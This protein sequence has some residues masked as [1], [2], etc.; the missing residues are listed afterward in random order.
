M[1]SLFLFP[2]DTSEAALNFARQAALNLKDELCKLGVS[3]KEIVGD[4]ANELKIVNSLVENKDGSFLAFGHGAPELFTVH[5]DQHPVFFLRNTQHLSNFVCYFLSCCTGKKIGPAAINNGALAFFGFKEDFEFVP[6]YEENF[7]QCVTSGIRQ[8]LTGGCKLEE[9]EKIT[10]NSFNA[11]ISR[12][13]SNKEYYAAEK[14]LL[15]LSVMVF[16]IK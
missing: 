14:L 7:I 4:D 1:E 15:D 8:F 10:N 9:I 13:I 5:E 2:K 6:N 3:T 16:L 12:L 11:E